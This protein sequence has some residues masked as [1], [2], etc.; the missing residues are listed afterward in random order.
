MACDQ[1]I[2]PRAPTKMETPINLIYNESIYPSYKA[3]INLK[4]ILDNETH[5]EKL[6]YIPSDMP[7]IIEFIS[8]TRKPTT[9]DDFKIWSEHP[10]SFTMILIVG[11][12]ILIIIIIV[13]YMGGYKRRDGIENQ[14][15]VAMPMR[16]LGFK[17]VAREEA[18]EKY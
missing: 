10:I 11:T 13:V 3:L 8:N 5:W 4:E 16:E 7:A 18:A 6:P 2:I 15:V 14:I 9:V 17:G 1:F 12:L